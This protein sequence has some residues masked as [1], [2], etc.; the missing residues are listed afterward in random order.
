VLTCVS[1]SGKKFAV[2]SGSKCVS[3]CYYQA[4]ENWWV[5]K[6]IKKHKSTYVTHLT[7]CRPRVY[8]DGLPNVRLNAD[9]G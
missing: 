4:A 7:A 2:S 3:V 6:I 9:V 8:S 5:S 1:L